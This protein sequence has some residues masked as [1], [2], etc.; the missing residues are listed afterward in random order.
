MSQC[1]GVVL[2]RVG[3][4]ACDGHDV[5]ANAHAKRTSKQHGS[6]T[7]AVNGVESREGHE[8]VDEV[9]DDLQDECVGQLLNVVGEVRGTVVD[10]SFMISQSTFPP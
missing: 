6:T 10:L 8:N 2:G 9:D 5:L 3:G 4:H 1:R 7:K